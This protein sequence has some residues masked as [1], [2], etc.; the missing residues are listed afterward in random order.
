[1]KN[2]SDAPK[3]NKAEMPRKIKDPQFK[4]FWDADPPKKDAANALHKGTD[5]SRPTARKT[6]PKTDLPKDTDQATSTSRPSPAA[7]G[8]TTRPAH[9]INKNSVPRND[10][11]AAVQHTS[12]RTVDQ[13]RAAEG[14]FTRPGTGAP[15]DR[16]QA[17]RAE[18][19]SRA[20][21]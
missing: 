2:K 14:K 16:K 20:E 6:T 1:M 11:P 19:S 10:K 18:H 13:T 12:D 4:P 3:R 5:Q 21:H 17:P 9:T 15:A 7:A 8:K